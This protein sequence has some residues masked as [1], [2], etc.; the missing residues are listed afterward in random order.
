MIDKEIVYKHLHQIKEIA[1]EL[2]TLKSFSLKELEEETGKR[3]QVE[4]G[5]Q[6]AIQNLLDIGSHILSSLGKNRCETYVDI[7]DGLATEGVIPTEFSQKI[8]GMAGLRNI[9]VHDYLEVDIGS[10]YQILQTQLEDFEAYI[11]V[12]TEY[13]EKEES[14]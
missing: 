14:S 3:W 13:V 11:R 6:I 2:E 4:R 9:L 7:I 12:I 8:R 1:K 5:L 10:L